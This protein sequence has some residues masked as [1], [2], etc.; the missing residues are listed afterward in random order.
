MKPVSQGLIN[1]VSA[2]SI[3]TYDPDQ[4]G[5]C[6]RRYFFKYVLGFKEPF[7]LANRIGVDTH[8]QIE[9]YIKTGK[10]VLGHLALQARHFI[11]V[12]NTLA[13]AEAAIQPGELDIS[14]VPAKGYIDLLDP[15]DQNGKQY[16]DSIGEF[17]KDPD[18]TVEIHDWKTTSN[19]KSWS[20]SGAQLLKTNQMPLYA[21]W[22]A[23]KY[24]A[25]HVRL[26]HVYMQ[27]K[28][29]AEPRKST[30]LITREKTEKLFTR[31]E[32]KVSVM[33]DIAKEVDVNLIPKNTNSC[34]SFGKECPHYK[35]CKKTKQDL[36]KIAFGER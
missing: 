10:N 28:G 5:G 15:F 21:T 26:S 22:A 23:R 6:P 25:S 3:N 2:S 33:K 17:S 19:I 14:G 29:R 24:D 11:P 13:I 32:G 34:F 31:L 20:K 30:I 8:D 4:E 36:V 27:T 18:R 35:R 12:G 9:Q 1:Y 7:T 16:I